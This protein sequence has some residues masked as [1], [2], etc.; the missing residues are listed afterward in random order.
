M[1]CVMNP[2]FWIYII[3]LIGGI[4]IIKII[5]PWAIAFFE[6]PDPL[7]R[8]LMIVLWMFI[9]AAGVYFLFELFGCVF[10]GGGLSLPR[11]PRG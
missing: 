4:A 7:A 3:F 9:A 8:I 11:I 5:I 1:T 2:G 6:L 10:S